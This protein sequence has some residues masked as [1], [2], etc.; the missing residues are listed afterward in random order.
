MPTSQNLLPLSNPFNY[1]CIKYV[2]QQQLTVVFIPRDQKRVC[3]LQLQKTKYL[4]K[5]F[6]FQYETHKM[7]WE[8]LHLAIRFFINLRQRTNMKAKC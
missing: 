8:K 5:P 7:L 4:I 1:L 6:M 2:I 3:N